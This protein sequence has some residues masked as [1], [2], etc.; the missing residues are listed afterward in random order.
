MTKLDS[1]F[2]HMETQEV[3]GLSVI[4]NEDTKEVSIAYEFG[5]EAP[6]S[7]MAGGAS[8]GIGDTIEEAL[9]DVYNDLHIT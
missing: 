6:D 2:E 4:R 8:Y 3:F 7:P 1:L 5:R 9:V